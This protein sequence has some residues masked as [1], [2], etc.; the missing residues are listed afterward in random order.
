MSVTSTEANARQAPP[1]LGS[2]PVSL[3]AGEFDTAVVE[4]PLRSPMSWAWLAAAPDGR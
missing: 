3:G 4:P 1:A 2:G